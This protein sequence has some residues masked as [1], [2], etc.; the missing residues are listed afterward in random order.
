[1]I[2]QRPRLQYG[3]PRTLWNKMTK[4]ELRDLKATARKYKY[5]H[6]RKGRKLLTEQLVH[7]PHL[8][9]TTHLINIQFLASSSQSSPVLLLSLSL[10]SPLSLSLSLSSSCSA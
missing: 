4:Q 1:M 9:N 10:F 2:K 5:L 8:V 3:P 6:G 7:L